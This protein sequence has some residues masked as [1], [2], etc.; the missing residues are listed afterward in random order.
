MAEPKDGAETAVALMTQYQVVEAH[1]AAFTHWLAGHA[2][3]LRRQPGFLTQ[4]VV[5]PLPPAQT[6]WITIARFATADAAL[7]WRQAPERARAIE[8]IRGT[9]LLHEEEVHVLEDKEPPAHGGASAFIAYDVARGQE[10]AFLAWQTAIHAEEQRHAGFVRH[11][12]E[13]PIP[14]IRDEWI[15]ILTFNTQANLSRWLDSPE[16]RTLMAQGGG[17]D[18]ESRLSRTSYGFDFWFQG[19]EPAPPRGWTIFKNNLLVLLVLNPIVILWS[20]LVAGPVLAAN[21]VPAWLTLFLGDFVSTQLLGWALAP[22]AFKAFSWWLKPRTD[23]RT[24]LAGYGA[25]A[26]LYAASMALHAGLLRIL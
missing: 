9:L 16:R 22:L 2:E 14:G 24:A 10:D 6:H 11:K 26:A 3:Q 13:R 15:I 7:Q 25:L 12:I 5:P 17:L 8:E 20:L 18:V 4:E 21:G 19:S 23:R 1:Y